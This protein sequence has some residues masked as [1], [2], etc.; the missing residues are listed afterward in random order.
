MRISPA[1]QD[2]VVAER[3]PV[4]KRRDDLLAHFH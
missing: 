2:Q 3:L 1:R 4:A